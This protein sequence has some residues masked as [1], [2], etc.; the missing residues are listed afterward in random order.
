M[1]QD[2][3]VKSNVY[4]E[5]F[6]NNKCF[7]LYYLVEVEIFATAYITAFP[8][9]LEIFRSQNTKDSKNYI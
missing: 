8:S 6:Y 1:D 4:R 9:R 7:I 2:S 5:T 3:L